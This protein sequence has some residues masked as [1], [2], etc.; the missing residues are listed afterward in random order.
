[1]HYG[2]RPTTASFAVPC[3]LSLSLSLSLSRSLSGR[4]SQAVFNIKSARADQ[5]SEIRSE[6][7]PVLCGRFGFPLVRAAV[8]TSPAAGGPFGAKLC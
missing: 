7:P 8:H 2:R 3:S 5:R 6:V 1:M 4:E